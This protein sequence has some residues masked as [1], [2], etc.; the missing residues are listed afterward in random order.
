MLLPALALA[1]PPTSDDRGFTD[2][3]DRP[4][5]DYSGVGDS[6]S[7]ELNPAL[8]S[9]VPGFDFSIRTY[10]ATNDFIRGGGFGAFASMNLGFGFALGF[11]A[12]ALR[13]GFRGDTFDYAADVN[14]NATK[15]SWALSLG[16]D[17]FGAIGVGFSTLRRR[18]QPFRQSDLDLGLLLRITRFVSLGVAS[19]LAPGDLDPANYPSEVTVAGELAVRP[20]GNRW[21]ELAG[22]VNARAAQDGD[23][24]DPFTGDSL[25]PRGR[26]AIRYQGL[27]LQGEV[28]Q[29]RVVNLEEGTLE[30]AGTSKAIRGSV[31]LGLAWDYIS[32]DVG[33]HAGLSGGVD[34]VGVAARFSS[35][36]QGRV[37]WA[38][39]ISVEQIDLADIVDERSLA[40]VL[41]QLR[42]AEKASNRGIVLL[43]A[44]DA[45]L[46]WASA[47]EVRD[48]MI[49]LRNAGGHVFAYLENADIK[50][51]YLAS[52]AEKVYM[53]KAGGLGLVGLSSTSLY[54][55]QALA[56][57]GVKVEALYIDEYKS[58]HEPFTRA[59]RSEPDRQQRQAL[60]DNNYDV[61]VHD[62][63]QARGLTLAETRVLIEGGPFLP[64]Q[65]LD[66]GLVDEIVYRDEVALEI[67]DAI[68][69]PV[70]IAPIP[71]TDPEQVAWSKRPYIA[72]ILV[73]G[74]I[75]DGESLSLPLFNIQNAGSDTINAAIAGARNDPSC[76]GIVLR[77]NSPGGSALASEVIWREVSKTQEA[78]DKDPRLSPP[79]VI[80]MGDV[81]ASG[82]YYVAAGAKHVFAEPTTL[83]GSI[84]V[85]S[86]NFDVSRLLEMLGIGVSTLKRGEAA[87]LQSLYRPL[88]D[89]ERKRLQA[90]MR[91]TYN[92]FIQRVADARGMTT[93]EVDKLGRGHVYS[94]EEAKK[95][96]LVDEMGG[97]EEAI[98]WVRNEA[99]I[100]ENRQLEIRLLPVKPT[101]LQL[102]LDATGPMEGP[103]QQAVDKRQKAK[104]AQGIA[105]IPALNEAIARLPLEILMVPRGEA[106]A[107]MPAEIEIR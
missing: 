26:L 13:P 78:F 27:T 98:A 19:T 38:R 72:V 86:L 63:A 3:V 5:H 77:V 105:G 29:I 81:A 91:G 48:A 65:A 62:V 31:S 73:E 104:A 23:G 51:Y 8:L 107:L 14:Q 84:G 36:R 95:L 11:G 10:T 43:D 103:L 97:Y 47:Q 106:L 46:G 88:S 68:G 76:K 16:D 1:Q 57:V 80:S 58:Y 49:D 25:F 101:L 28:E 30:F 96:G 83:T 33:V 42:Q 61:I 20:L 94:G 53:H 39:P 56:K 52:A 4:I 6:S 15:L 50:D 24:F 54:F 89:E 55:K 100:K 17:R 82:G 60:I 102:L 44:R 22:G 37:V 85:V 18:G 74:S 34:G 35:V 70:S 7:I 75:V 9:S 90:N 64:E 71:R 41:S 40:S 69:T 79:I 66:A 21:L 12:Q 2:G 45:G 67:G 99:G 87:D 92:L 32:A 93:E 59:D